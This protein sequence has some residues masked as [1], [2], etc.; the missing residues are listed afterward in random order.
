MGD[1][2]VIGV[3]SPFVGGLY[4]G[5]LLA[6][7]SDAAARRGLRTIAVQTLDAAAD[8]AVNGGNPAFAEPAAWRQ[9]GG[10]VVLTDA[11]TP[12]YL[13]RLRAAGKP[14]VLVG[15]EVPGVPCP[16]V[17]AENSPGIRDVVA[18]LVGHGHRRI[19]FT[20]YLA[21]T[22]VAE[23]YDAYRAALAGHGIGADPALFLPARD[24]LESGI[25]WTPGDWRRAGSPTALVAATDRNAIGA[26]RVLAAAGLRCPDDYALTGFDNIDVAAFLRPSL[27]T[28]AQPL[29]AMSDRAVVLLLRAIDG[30]ALEP[31]PERLPAALVART[32]CGCTESAVTLPPSAATDAA[33][34]LAERFAAAV[35]STVIDQDHAAA[36]A[37][38]AATA[39]VEALG[40]V[41]HGDQGGLAAAGDALEALYE[42]HPVPERLRLIC[43]AVQEYAEAAPVAAADAGRR[44]D[45]GAQELMMLLGRLNSRVMFAGGWHLRSLISTQYTLNMAL[46][47]G[48]DRDPRDP[49]WLA[50]T[51]AA[52]AAVA[53]RGPDGQLHRSPG[54][55]RRPGPP[56]PAGPTT[57]EAFPP[58]ELI[59]AAVPGETVFVVPA[60]IRGSDRGW[61]AVVDTVE[62]AVEDGRE[63]ANQCAALLTVALD[64]R[65]QEERL[66]RSALSDRL[67]A[68]PN[69]ESFQATL[70]AAVE[71][72]QAGGPPFTVLFL[73]L[74][75]FKAVNDGLG[76]AA[77]DELL[78]RVAQR[79]R[80]GLRATDVAARFGGDEF[81]VLLPGVAAGPDLDEIVERLQA[82]V[83]APFAIGG[84]Q[85]RI[86][87][88][89][90]ATG[91]DRHGTAEALLREADEAM[92]RVKAAGRP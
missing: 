80:A 78:V 49:S 77:G 52:A 43:R 62:C 11:V 25:T 7:V 85:V 66:R 18:H 81:V 21:A 36:V 63:L 92:Y 48:R 59:A 15:H 9:A 23:R 70:D 89:I 12:Q 31:G 64:L 6:G 69:R 2:R 75:G 76:H 65:E 35:P 17:L 40:R 39:T 87:V 68:L 41:A 44:V 28:A 10:F 56:I 88:S 82:A 20:G 90:G 46:L 4:Y 54:W 86:G 3:L 45:R 71:Q 1:G 33:G 34:R 38:R 55:R 50:A 73:D 13:M 83:R 27:T 72:A 19:A 32:S 37:A 60:K 58:A 16:A 26:Q 30:E 61:L 91:S 24:N 67:T 53:L 79:L 22:D 29:A 51:P 42:V 84:R 5:R 47:Y 74:D 57:V 14:V 8:V